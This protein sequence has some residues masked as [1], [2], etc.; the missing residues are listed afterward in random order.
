MKVLQRGTII[1]VMVF[2]LLAIIVF[3]V[4]QGVF[5]TFYQQ[6]E[7]QTLGHNIIEGWGILTKDLSIAQ[8]FF[9]E[10]RILSRLFYFI[11]LGIYQYNV[12][13]VFLFA[14]VSHALNA[15]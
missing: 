4:Y 9:A 8:I 3:V 13:P 6:D 12:T 14:I 5:F 11:F 2:L 15:W 7:W 1:R 10:G